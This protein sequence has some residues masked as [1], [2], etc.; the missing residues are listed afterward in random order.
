MGDGIMRKKS[1]LYIGISFIILFISGGCD[2]VHQMIHTDDL[3]K[4]CIRG[5][6]SYRSPKDALPVHYP[7]ATITAW[8]HGTDKALGEAKADAAGNYY[9]EVPMVDFKVDLR[10]WGLQRLYGSSYTC[11][12][13]VNAIDLSKS[14]KKPGEP[15]SKF[16]ILAEC[17]EYVHPGS[18]Y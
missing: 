12:G 3:L 18:T 14:P 4:A 9:L 17:K 8:Q 7:Y 11:N 15:C 13:S 16:D 5:T 10:V 2:T 6:I 1:F